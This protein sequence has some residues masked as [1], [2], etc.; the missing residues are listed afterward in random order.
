MS[1]DALKNN[2]EFEKDYEP[3]VKNIIKECIAKGIDIDIDDIIKDKELDSKE[4]T[5]FFIKNRNRF[6]CRMRRINEYFDINRRQF[7]LRCEIHSGNATELDKIKTGFGDFLLYGFKHEGKRKIIQ[8]FMGDL[9]IFRK[10]N[11]KPIAI[12]N[13]K[14]KDDSTLAAYNLSDLP[15]NFIIYSKGMPKGFHKKNIDESIDKWILKVN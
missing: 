8:W 10:H 14:G 6:A 5:D 2:M 9:R 13:N 15:D 4:A 7:T 12:C 11:P 3:D 1:N